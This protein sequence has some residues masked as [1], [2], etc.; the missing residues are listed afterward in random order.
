MPGGI[1][2][3]STHSFSIQLCGGEGTLDS[4]AP[5]GL[6]R[7][8]APA[9]CSSGASAL[10]AGLGLRLPGMGAGSWQGCWVAQVGDG[11]QHPTLVSRGH[12]GDVVC[13]GRRYCSTACPSP[14]CS[15][16]HTPSP[17]YT[18]GPLMQLH[19]LFC[20]QPLPTPDALAPLLGLF[21]IPQ[22][23]GFPD[24][25]LGDL[26]TLLGKQPCQ[27][28]VCPLAQPQCQS[29]HLQMQS[30]QIQVLLSHKLLCILQSLA[31]CHFL[32]EALLNF[33]TT[34]RAL[35]TPWAPKHLRSVSTFCSKSLH[36]PLPPLVCEHLDAR[37]HH[38]F[39]SE[40]YTNTS[41]M[42]STQ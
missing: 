18:Q 23:R 19:L 32:Q 1:P 24:L 30:P 6:D 20:K 4:K 29:L 16:S 31:S 11:S 3:F 37:D 13:P 40:A 8:C 33:F 42:P 22:C 14:W 9:C 10:P 39:I 25:A 5:K 17:D 21:P 41:G 38:L 27:Y 2:P 36:R 12:M 35:P 15:H 34:P 28:L 26:P 7:P